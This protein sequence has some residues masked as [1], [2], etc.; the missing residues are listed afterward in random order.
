MKKLALFIVLLGLVLSCGDSSEV[1][2]GEKTTMEVN[3]VFD[4]GTVMKGEEIKAVFKLTNTGDHPLVIVDVKGSC[5][6]TVTSKPE[7]PIAPGES[8]VIEAF[9]DTDKTGSGTI[10]KDVNI[11]ANTTPSMVKLKIKATVINK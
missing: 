7:E 4:A 11:V 6:C 5:T 1:S 3:E 10:V 9:V 2:I 8:A